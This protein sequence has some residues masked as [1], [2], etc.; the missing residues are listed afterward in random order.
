MMGDETT[1]PLWASLRDVIGAGSFKEDNVGTCWQPFLDSGTEFAAEFDSEITRI[2]QLRTEALAAAERQPTANEISDAPN[3]RF[4]YKVDKLHRQLSNEIRSQEAEALLQRALRLPPD[5]PRRIAF[6]QSHNGKCSN[7]LFNG[8]PD[9]FTPLTPSHP[10]PP[11]SFA[12]LF[13]T[14]RAPT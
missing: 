6:V 1:A 5:D 9:P 10:S 13:K 4:G 2:K 8:T 12:Q 14:K 3:N 11:P 7:T